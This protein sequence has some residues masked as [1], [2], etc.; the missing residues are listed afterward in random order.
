MIYEFAQVDGIPYRQRAITFGVSELGLDSAISHVD[1]ILPATGVLKVTST[2][3]HLQ[4]MVYCAVTDT[5][6]PIL[7]EAN[8]IGNNEQQYALQVYNDGIPH[9]IQELLLGVE[10]QGLY[11]DVQQQIPPGPYLANADHEWAPVT[12]I[13][14][15]LENALEEVIAYSD[16][17]FNPSLLRIAA[18]SVKPINIKALDIY[19]ELSADFF[20]GKQ[21]ILELRETGIVTHI[22]ADKLQS[23]INTIANCVG[24]WQFNQDKELFNR[25]VTA[26]RSYYVNF[27]KG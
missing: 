12:T 5:I 9:R 17:Y 1:Q 10:I 21:T 19:K 24:S 3:D 13:T 26:I 14:T 18:D 20:S 22:A 27:I 23:A 7:I 11:G 6:K 4:T 15:A 25:N 2:S 8:R 16:T